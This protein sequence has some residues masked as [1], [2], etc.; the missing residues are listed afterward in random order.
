MNDLLEKH[1]SVKQARCL[2]LFGALDIQKNRSG[3]FIARVTDPPP[4]AMVA[5]K[6]VSVLPVAS[7]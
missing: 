3:E 6:K 5:F 2:G 1:P 7:Q 4:P